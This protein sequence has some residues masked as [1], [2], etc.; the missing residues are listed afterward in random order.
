VEFSNGGSIY[1]ISLIRNEP[2]FEWKGN[3]EGIESNRLLNVM[4][5]QGLFER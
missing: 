2:F 4:I 1:L 5:K 3:I